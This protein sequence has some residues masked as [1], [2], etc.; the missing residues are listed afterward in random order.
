MTLVGLGNA[1][2]RQSIIMPA[3][4]KISAD[5]LYILHSGSRAVPKRW[6]KRIV[7]IRPMLDCKMERSNAAVGVASESPTPTPGVYG[8]QYWHWI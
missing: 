4:L 7:T 2:E 3:S 5:N 8:F 6:A 1:G